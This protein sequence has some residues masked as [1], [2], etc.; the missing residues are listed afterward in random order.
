[1]ARE[2][3]T[4]SHVLV[5]MSEYLPAIQ[6]NVRTSTTLTLTSIPL[7]V[8]EFIKNGHN[9]LCNPVLIFRIQMFSFGYIDLNC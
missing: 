5:I 3:L 7:P 6:V 9:H 4:S 1:V 8:N 2:I